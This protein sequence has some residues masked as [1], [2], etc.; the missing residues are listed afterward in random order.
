[1][2]YYFDDWKKALEDF[3]SSV[4]KDLEE[5]RQHKEEI[6]QVKEEIFSARNSGYF[7]RD[8]KRIV[9][10]APEII[11]G[12]VDR[13]GTLRG[14]SASHVVLRGRMLDIEGVGPDGGVKTRAAS[15]R[16]IAEDPGTDGQEAVVGLV[17]EIVNQAGSIVIDGN[18]TSGVFSRNPQSAGSGGVRIHA[19]GNLVLE[20]SVSSEVKKENLD[21]ILKLL[22]EQKTQAENEVD[23]GLGAFKDIATSIKNIQDYESELLPDVMAVRTNVGDLADIGELMKGY[24]A[25]LYK[26]YEECARALSRLAEINRQITCLKN[27]QKAIKKGDAY[28]KKPTGASVSIISERVDVLS[29]DGDGNIRDNE[30]AGLGIVARE[31]KVQSVDA[32]GALQK[33]GKVSV[34]AKTIELSTQNSQDIKYD[35]KGA[36]QSGTYPAEGDVVVKSKTV[37]FESIDEEFK[38]NKLQE[39]AFTKDGSFSVRMEK[40]DFSSTDTD[41]KSGGSLALNAKEISV[42]AM[43]VEKE[44]RTDDKLAAG[45]SMLLLA[46]KLYVGASDKDHKSKKLQAVS[47][48]VGIFADKTLEAQQDKKAILQFSGGKAALGGSETQ[49]YGKTTVNDATQVKGELKAPKATI[50]NLEA[51][52]SFKSQNISDGIAIPAPAAPANLSPKLTA[53]DAPKKK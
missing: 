23:A 30:G 19:D 27:E 6:R 13:D 25:N 47:E 41:G 40:M 53:E 17:S 50:D 48:E 39:K 12:D 4:T 7:L 9:I 15:I 37:T 21:D 10:S 51:K 14:S 20:A 16:Q 1:M 5:I 24:S 49:V 52:T 18:T 2:D 44:K 32:L 34:N 36:L 45:S 31:V 46:E 43:D 11:I 29:K 42:R 38:D 22:E 26:S 35:D 8:D 28:S 3:K 33:E